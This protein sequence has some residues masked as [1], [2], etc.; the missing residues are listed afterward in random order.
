V[1]RFQP[2]AETVQFLGV[3]GE[4]DDLPVLEQALREPDLAPAALQAMADLGMPEL[5][6]AV[7]GALETPELGPAA[8]AAFTQ[9]TGI[10]VPR[11]PAPP[12]VSDDDP[13]PDA[14]RAAAEWERIRDRFGRGRRHQ[15]GRDVD[16]QPLREA[17]DE[18]PLRSR[19]LVYLRHRLRHPGAT[20]DLELEARVYRPPAPRRG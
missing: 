1:R 13:P 16:A 17:L 11:A 18:L 8:A 6:P 15:H 9:I 19:R 4:P 2:A 12:A 7:L 10:D 20:P 5:L 14:A 3:V